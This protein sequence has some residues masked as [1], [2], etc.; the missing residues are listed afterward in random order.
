MAIN[1][2]ITRVLREHLRNPSS[3][4]SIGSIGAIAE[5]HRDADEPLII[6]EPKKQTITTDRGA[7]KVELTDRVRP[8]AYETLSRRANRW[9]H[10][11]VFCL[12]AAEAAGHRRTT[13]TE[14]GPDRAAV[15]AAD[16][17]AILFDMGLD[18]LNVDFCVRTDNP[19]LLSLLRQGAGQSVLQS[20]SPVMNAIVDAS[21]HRI[22]ISKL[23]RIEVYQAIDRIKTPEGPHTHVLPKFLASGRTHSA[24]IPVPRGYLPCLSLYPANPLFDGL[25]RDKPFEPE[26]FA[27]FE[28][29]LTL[30]GL[31][32]YCA[33]KAHTLDAVRQGQNP[34]AY[35][36]PK[37]RRGRTA[38][39]IALRQM[40]QS[41]GDNPFV[42]SWSQHFDAPKSNVREFAETTEG[43]FP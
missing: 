27:A 17:D 9:Q 12:P 19:Q 2:E 41:D 23:G 42:L 14:L 37:T 35:Q 16:R 40:R 13:L 20:G 32:E 31:P 22:A 36:C 43:S 34:T 38:L 21:P 18:A 39:R 6:D 15:R 10:G 7:L 8:L 33:E 30:W 25:G 1:P 5:F 11:V 4:F 28:K 24:N 3:S 29:L 26:T